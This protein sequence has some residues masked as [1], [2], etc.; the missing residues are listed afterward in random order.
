[1][2]ETPLTPNDIEPRVD[3]D[4]SKP[5]QLLRTPPRPRRIEILKGPIEERCTLGPIA[6][7]SRSLD[8]TLLAGRR[9]LTPSMRFLDKR[10]HRFEEDNVGDEVEE[11]VCCDAAYSCTNVEHAKSLWLWGIRVRSEAG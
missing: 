8:I 4:I 2:T 7:T 1:M 6:D 5:L 10:R 3:R 9:P 11:Y